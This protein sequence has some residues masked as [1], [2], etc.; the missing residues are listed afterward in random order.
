MCYDIDVCNNLDLIYIRDTFTY[1]AKL[2]I[3]KR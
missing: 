1:N 2:N 3:H